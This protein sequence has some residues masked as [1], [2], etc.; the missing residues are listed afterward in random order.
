MHL[1]SNCFARPRLND[2]L[3]TTTSAAW[4]RRGLSAQPTI[5]TDALRRALA[6]PQAA[7]ASRCS[8]IG[9]KPFRYCGAVPSAG[10]KIGRLPSRA[11]TPWSTNS[12]VLYPK[13][14][15]NSYSSQEQMTSWSGEPGSPSIARTMSAAVDFALIGNLFQES[16]R[17]KFLLS[18]ECRCNI[19][20]FAKSSTVF[21]TC[22][23]RRVGP[24][25]VRISHTASAAGQSAGGRMCRPSATWHQPFPYFARSTLG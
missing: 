9:R 11:F 25:R 8:R 14:H 16:T 18:V 12:A 22:E 23:M 17:T 1:L 7:N 21:T 19:I 6:S 2:V 4:S 5:R 15:P 20:F 10:T 13:T 3:S 24:S